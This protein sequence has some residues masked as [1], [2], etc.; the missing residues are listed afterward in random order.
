MK[1][2]LHILLPAST[3]LHGLQ[4]AMN[5]LLEPHRLKHDDTIQPNWK[6]DYLCLFDATLNCS[7]TDAELPP[8]LHSDFAGYISKVARLRSDVLAGAV[9]TPD[10]RWHDEFD[11]GTSFRND[12]ATN[13][14]AMEKWTQHYWQLMR[15]HSDCWVIETWAHS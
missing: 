15:D 8:E 9:L 12:A 2:P 10:G 1:T 13:A 4:D 11:F 6:F 14:V 7:E 3:T 5:A